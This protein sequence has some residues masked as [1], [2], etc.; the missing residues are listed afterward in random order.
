MNTTAPL[1]SILFSPLSLLLKD[2]GEDFLVRRE[3]ALVVKAIRE[4]SR[5][6]DFIAST[7]V[8]D[9]HREVIDQGSWNLTHYVGNPIVLYGHQSSELPIGHATRAEV[10]NG[11]LECT[12]YIS[13]KTVK[14]REVWDLIVEKTLRAVSVG[15]KPVN[16][17]YETR[18]GQDVW[19]WSD[20]I[21]KE[22]SVVAVPANHEALAKIKSAIASASKTNSPAPASGSSNPDNAEKK[23]FTIM[24]IKEALAKIESLT[25]D[26]AKLEVENKQLA[27]KASRF[28]KAETSHVEAMSKIGESVKKLETEKA[29]LDAQCKKLETERDAE[30]AAKEK[31]EKELADGVKKAQDEAAEVEVTALITTGTLDASEKEVFAELR[32]SNPELFTKMIAQRGPAKGTG[33]PTLTQPILARKGA[34]NGQPAPLN[35]GNAREA[36]SK[37]MQLDASG[38]T[39]A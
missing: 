20:C 39:K 1:S 12:L 9:A 27:E 2:A 34:E 16:G 23:E 19:V 25:A 4:G 28:E 21:L 3:D 11:R 29:A 33:N 13:D 18:D 32:K 10:K 35:G 17:R 8:V 30:K 26:K 7:D 24:D 6:V 22:I 14:A 36:I 15:F 31:A 38:A 5:E 37:L